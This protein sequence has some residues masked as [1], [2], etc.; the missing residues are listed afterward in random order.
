M[1]LESNNLP[2]FM[3]EWLEIIPIPHS[4]D[5]SSEISSTKIL[6]SDS[7]SWV[8]ISSLAISVYG[9]K[10]VNY[11]NIILAFSNLSLTFIE[12]KFS[13]DYVHHRR[14]GWKIIQ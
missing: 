14:M 9:P 13:S 11:K 5:G 3:S 12:V 6:V 1:A 2:I 4:I 8:T 7:N 10:T